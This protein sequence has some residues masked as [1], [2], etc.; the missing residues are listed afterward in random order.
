MLK[1]FS[2]IQKVIIKSV[3]LKYMSG[4]PGL[5]LRKS[6]LQQCTAVLQQFVSRAHGEGPI[7]SAPD[8]AYTRISIVMPC[9]NQV[10]F[11][12][13]SIL[14]VLNQDYPNLSSSSWT[15]DPPTERLM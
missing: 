4:D 2:G 15:E 10:L 11:I 1:R 14:S 3:L 5:G 12:E 9:Y 8:R 6:K 13:R 7:V